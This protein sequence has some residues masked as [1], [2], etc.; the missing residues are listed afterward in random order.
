M[1][2]RT[3]LPYVAISS[4][5]IRLLF[6]AALACG[7]TSA[8]D[9]LARDDDGLRWKY[10]IGVDYSRGDYGIEEDTEIVFLPF[11]V[12]A[13]GKRTRFKFTIPI[14]NVDGPS[15]IAIDADGNETIESSGLG[16]FGQMSGRFGWFIEPF[17][18]RAPWLELSTKVS[19]PTESDDSLGSGEWSFSAQLDLF[20]RYGRVSPFGRFGRKF[21]ADRLDDRFYTSIGSSFRITPTFSL[22]ASYDWTQASTSGADDGHDIVGFASMKLDS[23]WSIGP[24]GLAGLTDG[25]PDYGVG[26]TI[27]FRPGNR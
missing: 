23:V 26:M 22:G 21:Y 1:D 2:T 27:H 11:S 25:S 16:G 14:I 15:A 20:Q 12:E 7:L 18:R 3:P 5:S 6:F 8:T 10:S 9:A 19:A 17:H 4:R 24:Y 13:S